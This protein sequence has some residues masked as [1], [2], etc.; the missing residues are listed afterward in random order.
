M[1][2]CF[3]TKFDLVSEVYFREQEYTVSMRP[4][5]DFV[6]EHPITSLAYAV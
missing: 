2:L 3:K 5:V 4:N 6:L 1:K